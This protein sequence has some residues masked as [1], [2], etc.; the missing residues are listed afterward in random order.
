MQYRHVFH[1]GNFADVHKHVALLA[2]IALLQKKAKGFLY[3]DTHAGAGLYD[4]PAPTRGAA[5]RATAASH[6]CGDAA[7]ARP[8]DTDP[9]I[10]RLPRGIDRMR[11]ATGNAHGY[12]GSPLLAAAAAARRRPRAS[13][14][15]A[16]PQQ[17]R[18]LQRAIDQRRAR[19]SRT[20]PRVVTGDGYAAAQ[21]ARCRRR[22]AARWCCIDPPYEQA[23]EAAQIATALADGL[24]ALRH[25]RLRAVVS[26][27]ATARHRPVAR[28]PHPRHLATGAGHRAVRAPRR[29]HGRP[30]RFGY[31]RHQSAVAVRRGSRALAGRSCTTCS[32]APGRQRRCAG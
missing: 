10:T 32:A 13:A 21:G 3:L 9:A 20:T 7:A 14:S 16:R 1:A 17:A 6:G 28:A 11:A 23:D 25:R 24:A 4:L 29:Q 2:L 15:R 27:Q 31:A 18:A 12:P 19:S 26:H 5:A 8:I 22:S 30:E